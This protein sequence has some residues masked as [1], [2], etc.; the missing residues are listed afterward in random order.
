MESTGPPVSA[1]TKRRVAFNTI[2]EIDQDCAIGK[3]SCLDFGKEKAGPEKI[4]DSVAPCSE[5]TRVQDKAI[6]PRSK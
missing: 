5:E 2:D 6:S 3:P 1:T 4:E